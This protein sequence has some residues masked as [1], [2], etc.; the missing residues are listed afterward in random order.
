MQRV[1]ER[2]EFQARNKKH[3]GDEE[4]RQETAVILCCLD[5]EVIRLYI[6][7][8]RASYFFRKENIHS[9]PDDRFFCIMRSVL[10][11]SYFKYIQESLKVLP[12]FIN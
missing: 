5:L 7:R 1:H 6:S 9:S 3:P 10:R 12:L 4:N 2:R 11:H 8:K